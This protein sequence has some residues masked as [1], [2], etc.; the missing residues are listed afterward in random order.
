MREDLLQQLKIDREAPVHEGTTHIRPVFAGLICAVAIVAGVVMLL[1]N[2]ENPE[3]TG[4]RP[5]SLI[6][7][8]PVKSAGLRVEPVSSDPNATLNATG[9]VTARRVATVSAK[10]TGKVEKL[11]IEEGDEVFEGQLLAQLESDVV[12]A[13]LALAESEVAVKK[14]Q[15]R[16]LE[17]SLVQAKAAYRRA[18]ALYDKHLLSVAELDDA[19]T[20]VELIEARI[21]SRELQIQVADQRVALQRFRAREMEIRAPFSGVVVAKTAQ[22]GEMI[23]PVSAGGGFTRTGIGTLVDM[24]SL[25]VEVD[26]S[27]SSINRIATGQAV[28]VTLNAYPGLQIPAKVITIV[29]TANRSKATIKVRIGFLGRDHRALPDMGV[30]VVFY[31]RPA[32]AFNSLSRGGIY[33]DN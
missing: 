11:F 13:E 10:V 15:V 23:S 25:E 31:D 29:P 18:Q 28:D 6:E 33:D 27:E 26:V 21:R 1:E 3:P 16:E 20:A 7:S 2:A 8:N 12:L 19:E 5:D 4:P 30:R 32:I 14:A 9:Y 22:P 17:T 24:S